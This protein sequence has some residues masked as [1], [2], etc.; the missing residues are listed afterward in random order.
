MLKAKTH[1][2]ETTLEL[3]L[4]GQL[5]E[6][7]VAGLEQHLLVCSVCRAQLEE[8]EAYIRAMKAAAQALTENESRARQRG[9]K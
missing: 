3:Y 1:I 8:S 7:S 4:F 5:A 6:P 2:D 9:G